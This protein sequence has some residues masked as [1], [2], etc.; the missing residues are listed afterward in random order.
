MGA[1]YA[2]VLDFGDTNRMDCLETRQHS[3]AGGNMASA[4]F[5]IEQIEIRSQY[6]VADDKECGSSQ[7]LQESLGSLYADHYRSVLQVCR[8]FFRRPEDAEDAAAEVYVKLHRVLHTKDEDCPFRPWVCQLAGRHC[9]DK[10]RRR[11]TETRALVSGVDVHAVAD[12]SMPS[13]LSQ[14]LHQEAKREVRKEL[15][16]LPEHYR[17]P[18]ILR[19][20]KRMSY[21][22]IARALNRRLPAVRTMIFRAKRR[23]Q[24]NLLGGDKAVRGLG[25]DGKSVSPAVPDLSGYR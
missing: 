21:F 16:R 12:T 13:P 7:L 2:S 4:E 8:R 19:Y 9:I 23:L 1:Q 14:M 10:L 22:D 24:R 18:L 15:N 5:G 6:R 17:I 20:Y 25:A 3:A 11:K